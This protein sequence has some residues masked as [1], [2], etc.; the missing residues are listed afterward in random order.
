MQI[1]HECGALEV[2]AQEKAETLE[3]YV[4]ILSGAESFMLQERSFDENKSC[5]GGLD[6]K[7]DSVADAW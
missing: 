5:A 7:M 4:R 3:R 2:R 6:L 1:I